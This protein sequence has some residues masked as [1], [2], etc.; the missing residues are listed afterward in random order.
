MT[1]PA[2]LLPLLAAW[3]T[4]AAS[5]LLG[6]VLLATPAPVQ[7]AVCAIVINAFDANSTNAGATSPGG[8]AT[9]YAYPGYTNS[10]LV[11]I[12]I[13]SED[14][15]SSTGCAN[16]TDF[17]RPGWYVILSRTAGGVIGSGTVSAQVDGIPSTLL[18]TAT[19]H[20]WTNDFASGYD[21][22]LGGEVAISD[23]ATVTIYGD[24]TNCDITQGSTLGFASSYY[25][26]H[27]SGTGSGGFY[28]LALG[29]S[30]TGSTRRTSGGSWVQ[31]GGG[32]GGCANLINSRALDSV[33]YD[34]TAP[35]VVDFSS[36][37]PTN[38]STIPLS[39]N[40]SD[41]TAPW[42]M[43]FSNS[44][45]CATWS[46]WETYAASKS[47]N[48]NTTSFGG[49][50]GDGTKTV[51][52]RV[53]DRGGNVASSSISVR[54]D[55]IAPTI[56]SFTTGVSSVI[57]GTAV[58]YSL[59]YS[60][61]VT[62]VGSADFTNAGS[63]TGCSFAV[64]GSGTSRTLSV[65]GCGAGTLTPRVGA[66]S[67]SDSAGNS[68]GA[69]VNGPTV[70]ITPADAIPPTVT[71]F[72][73]STTSDT[74]TSSSDGITNAATLLFD[75]VFSESVT[76]LA[77][78]DFTRSGT[79]AGCAT[80][81]VTGSGSS[82]TV[83][84]AGCGE[85]TLTLTL[86][87]NTVADLAAN[88]GPAVA[89][90]ASAG[91]TID[92][93]GPT[94][95]SL[96]I[97]SGAAWTTTAVNPLAI[98]C[99]G[100]VVGD[101]MRVSNNG[102]NYSPTEAYATSKS[103]DVT[104]AAYGGTSTEGVKIVT[105]QATDVAGNSATATDSIIY[106]K[107]VPAVSFSSPSLAGY[108][109]ATG[110]TVTYSA[111]DSGTGIPVGGR[112]V[113]R[114]VAS[115]TSATCPASGYTLEN[116]VADFPSGTLS[117]GLAHGKCYYWTLTATDA[118]GNSASATSAAI[119]V[120]QVAPEISSVIIGDGSGATISTAISAVATASDT[121][122][123][124]AK[125]RWSSE[126]GRDW[127]DSCLQ[128]PSSLPYSTG[129]NKPDISLGAGSGDYGVMVQVCDQA[130][131]VRSYSGVV[132]LTSSKTPPQL[133]LGARIVDCAATGS[134]LAVN[135]SGVVY[136]PVGK[137][138]CL[139][140]LPAL[141]RPGSD[142]TGG[143]PLTG[144]VDPNDTGSYTLLSTNPCPA[145]SACAGVVGLYPTAAVG[146][147]RGYTL[148]AGQQSFTYA[149]SSCTVNAPITTC[150]WTVPEN[151]T[152]ISAVT[153]GAGGGG[154]ATTSGG[155]GGGGGALAWAAQISVTPGE[156]LTVE[157]GRGGAA[158]GTTAGTGGT[159][160]IKRGGTV[161][162]SAGGGAGASS[163][164]GGLGGV[165]GGSERDGGGDGGNGGTGAIAVGGGGGGA[166]GYSGSG[167]AGGSQGATTAVG[168]AG[169]SATGGAGGGGASGGSSNGGA[170]GG[171]VGLIG[172]GSNGDGGVVSSSI[173][174]LGGGAG[175]F[176]A[177]GSNGTA[178]SGGAGGAY[179]GGGGGADDT[180][181]L[182]AGANGAAKII[183]GPGRNF[184]SSGMA[185]QSSGGNAEPL[186][187]RL[188]RE[189]T[190]AANSVSSVSLVVRL[191]VRVRWYNTAGALVRT[192]PA[193]PVTLELRLRSFA[194]GVRPY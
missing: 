1:R 73:R 59:T 39:I 120:D 33:I 101:Q 25:V 68:S 77:G 137:K 23:G 34:A 194:A 96:I 176:G 21:L 78:G 130:G 9:T 121:L 97:A 65:T 180:G 125:I 46:N 104:D 70:T 106:D 13:R 26:R 162:L 80:P 118:A 116:A 173:Y 44:P 8:T 135:S 17:P 53:M 4:M 174:G 95:C 63:A 170:G 136:W 167:G 7:A 89:A 166:G 114:Y 66:G 186:T 157:I 52:M 37:S 64:S 156:V 189:T 43:A 22:T 122:S 24:P 75:L 42:L 90:A 152:S 134:V 55:T 50:T 131:N 79:A 86:N 15:S 58:S 154:R 141:A 94:G 107:T 85:G 143:E 151:V 18:T 69:A 172:I 192:D 92:R 62:G 139:L 188:D 72:T 16:T 165:G 159:T 93:T 49:T 169:S 153:I 45:T 40:V 129:R 108:S 185:D 83:S 190:S 155:G 191:S 178:A 181:L 54:L 31:G 109:N 74:G 36:A 100:I 14:A 12:D 171:G 144:I 163:L 145:G 132:T 147:S 133:T 187:I 113:R 110:Y 71:S 128:S 160:T 112:T 20:N 91:F 182:G 32:K 123:G 119:L 27:T 140:P 138:L 183:W 146:V 124:L 81:T 48:I 161:L 150:S 164:T 29:A 56:S 30:N 179:G 102:L 28:W 103:W 82:Y 175:S 60:E 193:Y 11:S 105:L 149:M 142:S 51:C 19:T 57:A 3:S 67:F 148:A 47:W 38:L 115:A 117:T 6:F 10:T 98:S 41:N 168:A 84:V 35:T 184:P 76:G 2:A 177:D 88:P 5:A 127:S 111:S 126:S 87:I 61:S 99:V 158:S